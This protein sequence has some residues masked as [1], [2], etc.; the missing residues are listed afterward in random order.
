MSSPARKNF[1][2][3]AKFHSPMASTSPP[4]Q[5][6][7]LPP[8]PPNFQFSNPPAPAA[9]KSHDQ[10]HGEPDKK[11]RPPHRA[12]LTHHDSGLMISNRCRL[13]CCAMTGCKP[14]A[15]MP[16]NEIICNIVVK[17]PYSLG[18]IPRVTIGCTH[19]INS[20]A[21]GGSEHHPSALLK[22]FYMMHVLFRSRRFSD[23]CEHER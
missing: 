7:P 11:N 21:R 3:L 6:I 18:G 13:H 1:V 16:I 5:R 15:G 2:V 14:T 10:N 4:N 17:T 22:K 8:M 23:F 12:K 20:A 9:K 19:H